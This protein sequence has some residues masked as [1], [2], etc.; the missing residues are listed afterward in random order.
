MRQIFRSAPGQKT[1]W[2]DVSED[3]LERLC[4]RDQYG[5]FRLTDAVRPSYDL[6]IVPKQGYRHDY[7][8]D[9]KDGNTPVLMAAVTREKLFEVFMDLIDPMG[10]T[11]DVALETSHNLQ[12]RGHAELYREHIDLPVL[13]SILWEYEN[14]LTN[15]GG[16]GIAVLNPAI[17]QE[18]RFD[19]HKLLIMYGNELGAFE[20]VLREHRIACREQIQFITEAEHLHSTSGRFE[21]EFEELAVRLGMDEYAEGQTTY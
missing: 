12:R 17:P 18:V 15:D 10:E 13:K 2:E 1:G 16:T 7:Y 3:D 8:R 19:E 6:R 5:D 21:Q 11:V 14:L 9:P 20:D 4:A